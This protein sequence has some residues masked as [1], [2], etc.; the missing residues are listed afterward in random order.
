MRQQGLVRKR[1][2]GVFP[3]SAPR[4]VEDGAQDR[5]P[6]GRGVSPLVCAQSALPPTRPFSHSLGPSLCIFLVPGHGTDSMFVG[7]HGWQ[8]IAGAVER[9]WRVFA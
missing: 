9:P 4:S 1:D 8:S 6:G 5:Q 2:P 3:G 7:R